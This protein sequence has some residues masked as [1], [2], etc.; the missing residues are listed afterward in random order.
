[1]TTVPMAPRPAPSNGNGS[2]GSHPQGNGHSGNGNGRRSF[3]RPK[4]GSEATPA[5][6]RYLR[7]LATSKGLG[8]ESI[9][10][11]IERILPGR[12]PRNLDRHDLSKLIE[13]LV[14]DEKAA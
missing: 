13:A 10:Q 11:I 9:R 4:P 14:G 8:P 1:M 5:Q 3:G 2:N 12:D 7:S 6:K